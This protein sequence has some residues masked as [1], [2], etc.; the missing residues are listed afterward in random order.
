ML[1]NFGATI[2]Q[3]LKLVCVLSTS[4]G[5]YSALTATATT[6]TTPSDNQQSSPVTAAEANL[7]ISETESSNVSIQTSE[8]DIDREIQKLER[9]FLKVVGEARKD[10]ATVEL[11][12]VKLCVTQLPV[13]VKYQHLHLL[14]H[15]LSA[16]VDAK[17]VDAIFTVLGRYWN[18]LN[19]E[20]LNEV[21]HQLGSDATKQLMEQ[22]MEKLQQFRM[23]TKLG[24]FIG[25]TTQNV[26]P[27]FTTFATE[28]GNEWRKRTL[29]DLQ[30]FRKKVAYFMQLKEYAL[31]FNSVETG[32]IA[33]TWAFHSSL[34]EIANILQ[35]TFEM[36]EKYS[37]LRIFFRGKSIPQQRA[38]EVKCL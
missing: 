32:S 23:N 14:E 1:K 33:V 11:S 38:L 29:E 3:Q 21:V 9:Q 36:I 6:P 7:C 15:N 16:I 4:T 12:E 19:C 10:L 28:M 13:S 37:V 25:M 35:A 22:Y 26:P 31:H 18:F 8:T 24:D 27:H 2:I 17:S 20:L 34:P 5:K 30:N